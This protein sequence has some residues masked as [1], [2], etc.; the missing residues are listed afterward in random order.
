MVEKEKARKIAAKNQMVQEIDPIGKKLSQMPT[1]SSKL[2]IGIVIVA[3][4][5]YF[6]LGIRFI[7]RF[8]QFYKGNAHIKFFIFTDTDPIPYLQENID[9]VHI[10][11]EHKNWVDGTN[12]KFRNILSLAEENIDYLFYFDADTNVDK[13][14]TEEWF[15]GDLVGGQHYADQ[16]WMKEKKGFDRNPQSKAYVPYDTPYKQMYFYGAFFGGKKERMLEF[17]NMLLK[18]QLE[19]KM[20]N[21]EPGTNDESY[22][23]CYF[24]YFPP[25]KIVK[26][27][28]FEFLISDKGGIGET[29][30]MNLDVQRIKNELLTKK[31]EWI[32]IVNNQVI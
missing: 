31:N 30:R 10:H 4:N 6:V 23:N 22:I 1:L 3:T 12:S 8:M 26:T 27:V 24:H 19:D 28:D 7:K 29:R 13:D 14:F 20:I 16:S 18:W 15:L 9:V 32:N 21:Y 2:R 5:A 25:E 11:E 17:C